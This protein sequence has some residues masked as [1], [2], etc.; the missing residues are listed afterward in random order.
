MSLC[1]LGLAGEFKEAGIAFNALWPKTAIETAA[2]GLIA[3]DMLRRCRTPDIMADAAHAILT[4]DSR[5]CTGHFFIDEDVL[6]GAGV[7]DFARYRRDGVGEQ[8]LVP[9]F[10]V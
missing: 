3:P 5:E 2:I 4:R 7:T 6:R 9:D 1:V 8:E 10:F